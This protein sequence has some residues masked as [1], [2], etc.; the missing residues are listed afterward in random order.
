M[1]PGTDTWQQASD[2]LT[3]IGGGTLLLASN[4][5][6]PYLLRNDGRPRLA[7]VL[8]SGGALLNILLNYIMVGR[9]GLGLTGTAQA[10]L[11]EAMVSLL[12][13]GYF[14]TRHARLRLT[15]CQ[16]VPRFRPCPACSSPGCR[17]SSPSSIWGCC[18][19]CTTAS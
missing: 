14:F 9:L 6:V 15:W 16:L 1:A 2:Y 5:A 3:W 4:L 13:L 7:M 17:A 19:C 10:T 11:S 18:C 12:G 8:V